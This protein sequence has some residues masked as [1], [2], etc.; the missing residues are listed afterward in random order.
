MATSELY[1]E[2]GK[3]PVVRTGAKK[4]C[5]TKRRGPGFARGGEVGTRKYRGRNTGVRHDHLG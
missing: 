5:S 2:G 3:V 4:C 1:M